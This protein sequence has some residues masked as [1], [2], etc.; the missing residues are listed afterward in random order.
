MLTLVG[1][2]VSGLCGAIKREDIATAVA[3]VRRSRPRRKVKPPVGE[4]GAGGAA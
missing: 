4:E 1:M 2:A 3:L